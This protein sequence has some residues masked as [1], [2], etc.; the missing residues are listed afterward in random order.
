[1]RGEEL[2]GAVEN[3]RGQKAEG[4]EALPDRTKAGFQVGGNFFS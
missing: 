2:Q 4:L 3:A 1:M